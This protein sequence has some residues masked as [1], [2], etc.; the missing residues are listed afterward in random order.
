[1]Q[2]A[3]NHVVS[4]HYRLTGE[5]GAVIDS[6][7]EHDEPLR[8]LIGSGNIIPGLEEA[9]IGHAQGDHFDVTVVPDKAYGPR[10]ENTIQRVSKKYFQHPKRL[11]PG[12]TTI[13]NLRD[14]GHQAVT[15]HKV[16][17]T[18]I[19]VDTNHPLAGKTLHFAIEIAAVREATAEEQEHHHVHGPDGQT[20]H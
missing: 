10:R 14:G 3:K 1:M 13:L 9:L 16:G 5:D 17:M 4:F 7:Y 11:Q 8:A 15:V 20:G 2:I 18:M 12:A 6:S 19:D